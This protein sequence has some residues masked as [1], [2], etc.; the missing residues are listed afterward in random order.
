MKA[1]T[2]V[3]PNGEAIRYVDRK[4]WLW[5]LSVIYPLQ[6]F[7]P[8]C[9]H[10][11]SGS[12]SWFVLLFVTNFVAIPILDMIIGTDGDNPPEQVAMQLNLDPYYRYLTYVTVGVHFIVILGTTFYAA[13]Q[14]LSWWAFLLF[15]VQAGFIGGLA[16]NTAHE[17]GHK[18]SRLEKYLARLA[19][20]VPCYGHF[21]GEHNRG[22]HMLV[23]TPDD[24]AS[25]RMGESIYRFALREIPG[26]FL[27]GWKL[28]KARLRSRDLP[29]WHR[30]NPILQ[31]YAVS[32]AVAAFLVAAAGWLAIPFLLVHHLTA[33]WQLT[34]ANYIEHYGLLREK[35]P[36]GRYEPCQPHHSWNSNQILSNLILF[37]LQRH[38][39]HHKNPLRRYQSLRNYEDLPSLPN[40][41]LGMF[42]L[43]WAP[44]LWFRVMDKR[45]MSLSH[46]EG[47]LD[48]VNVDP[49]A[50]ASVFLRWGRTM[51]S[52][53]TP[54]HV[55]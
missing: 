50:A 13:T 34:S 47:N 30:S 7:L 26:A 14:A 22:H 18:S 9:L 1:Y 4:R 6:A 28:E 35:Q 15:A 54:G 46:I 3:L 43:A 44:P 31:S 48:K 51:K 17:L 52:E 38:S 32:L 23:S 24:T 33:Y 39:D 53:S 8:V 20:G 55:P 2:G 41:Y 45:L 36:D 29:L 49:R 12:E 16:I 25:S 42:V 21:T 40:G 11:I 37:H 27:R 5:L 10:H 19:L